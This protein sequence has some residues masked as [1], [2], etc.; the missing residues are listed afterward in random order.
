LRTIPSK[1]LSLED[2]KAP[3][4]FAEIADSRA[5][6]CWSPADRSGQIDHAGGGW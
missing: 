5:A 4:I 2:L 6:S 1:I 3:K